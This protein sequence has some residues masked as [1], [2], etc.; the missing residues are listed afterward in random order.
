[1]KKLLISFCLL[2]FFSCQNFGQLEMI[3][4]LPKVLEEVSGTETI[5]GS[6]L[7]WMLNDSGNQPKL[8]AVS[9]E[10]KILKE[11]YVKTKN[12]DWEDLTA[13]K[14]GNLYIGDFG[15]NNSKRKNLRILKVDK[16]YLNKKNAEVEKIEFEYEDQNK[17][18]PKKKNLFFDSESFFYYNN[19]FYI[20]TKSR[21]KKKY[22]KTSLYRI[23]A[24]KGKHKAKLIGEFDNGKKLDS[25]ITSADISD[26]GK[27]V[28]L[29]SQKNILIFTDFKGDN[30]LSGNVK[31]I[32]LTH[33]SQ[34]EGIT[35]KNNNTLLITDEKS[36]GEGGNLYK[37]K[38]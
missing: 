29:L 36:G 6:D 2:L 19:H 21:T 24:E 30:F 7:I 13:D 5:K 35:F 33:K 4:D 27:K 11:I 12:H 15:N 23:P 9:E 31:E 28:V 37:I 18:P 8:F 34:K 10:G 25:W 32:E 14:N 22:G 26:D 20:F 16:K 38:F 3:A 1:M 17:F